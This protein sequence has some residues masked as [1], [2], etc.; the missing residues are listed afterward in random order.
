MLKQRNTSQKSEKTSAK[1][2]AAQNNA[3]AAAEQSQS[4]SKTQS[5]TPKPRELSDVGK[6]HSSSAI[7][8]NLDEIGWTNAST[9]LPSSSEKHQYRRHFRRVSKFNPYTIF[10]SPEW[11]NSQFTG[12]YVLFWVVITV[13]SVR[14]LLMNYLETG[15]PLQTNI[16]GTL[17]E[18]LTHVA[19]VDFVMYLCLY[20]VYFG[21]LLVAKGYVNWYSWGWIVQHIYQ[22]AFLGTFVGY[23]RMQNL[24][25]I[26][27]I[28]LTLHALVQ[29]MKMHS[30]AVFN[31]YMK[32]LEIK[33]ASNQPKTDLERELIQ[34]ATSELEEYPKN[35]KLH[36]F[37]MY[38]M[39]PT[40]VYETNY[41]RTDRIRWGYAFSKISA[42][43]GIFVVMIVVAEQM[44]HPVAVWANQ[45]RE[46]GSLWERVEGYPLV[47]LNIFPPFVLLYLLTFYI[48]WDAILNS[49]AELTMFGD[50][51][52]YRDWW[53]STQWAKFARDWNVP[54]HNFLQR[55]VYSSSRLFLKLSRNQAM[56]FTFILSSFVHELAMYVI[57]GRVR[58][59][60]LLMQLTQLPMQFLSEVKFFKERPRFGLVMFWFGI[61]LGPSILCSL[62]LTF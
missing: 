56:T 53:N 39:Y 8:K 28:F 13:L 34:Q 19:L 32:T 17:T 61:A 26:A 24:P 2:T 38:T 31:G 60:L 21:Q 43:M 18:D 4:I 48:I 7:G 5:H 33:I 35:L 15:S 40:V 51:E 3:Q 59:Y 57:F 25:W 1:T 29:L 41:P 36:D 46:S 55:H 49:I 22:A 9:G 6:V 14:I 10:D 11:H 54:V 12:F 47:F 20:P 16:I 62:Y 50:R 44:M 52:F 23:A 27:Q 58:G 45:L 42:T 37:F 30:F